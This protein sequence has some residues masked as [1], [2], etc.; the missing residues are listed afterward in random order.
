[1]L[2]LDRVVIECLGGGCSDGVAEVDVVTDSVFGT[3]GVGSIFPF[4]VFAGCS[5][6]VAAVGC[7]T[8]GEVSELGGTLSVVVDGDFT[9]G[10]SVW[11]MV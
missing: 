4:S 7:I 3:V 11:M 6:A 9:S 2:F 10:G 5:G 8:G 1:M